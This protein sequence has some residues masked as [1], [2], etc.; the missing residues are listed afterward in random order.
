MDDTEEAMRQLRVGLRCHPC[1]E[2]HFNRESCE[3]RAAFCRV[4]ASCH[5]SIRAIVVDISRI[6]EGTILRK[7]PKHFYNYITGLLFQHNFGS[8]QHAKVRI[9]GSMNRDLRTYLRKKL[10]IETQVISSVEFADS[11]K[12][13]LIQLA[14]MVAGSITRSF[15]PDKREYLACLRL[16]NQRIENVWEF[17]KTSHG[18]AV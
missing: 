14:D 13:P 18:D 5:F 10:N 8:I 1:H 3:W 9:D 2:F 12:T 16:L 6:Y 11:S 15:Y 7:S 4:G 17:G